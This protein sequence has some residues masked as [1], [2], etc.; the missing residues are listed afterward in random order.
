MISISA[1]FHATAPAGSCRS[2]HGYL[3]WKWLSLTSGRAGFFL[4]FTL[5]LCSGMGFA[6][7]PVITRAP[8]SREYFSGSNGNFSVT[9][10][11][12]ATLAYQWYKDGVILSNAAGK[13]S[14]A[15]ASS[16]SVTNLVPGDAGTYACRVS[17][18]EGTAY[19]PGAIARILESKPLPTL[20]NIPQAVVVPASGWTLSSAMTGSLPLSYQ[21]TLNSVDIAGATSSTLSLAFDPQVAGTYALRVTNGFGTTTG[22]PIAVAVGDQLFQIQDQTPANVEGRALVKILDQNTV[23]PDADIPG[24]TFG[25][26]GKMRFREGSILFTAG[27]SFGSNGLYRWK[28]GTLERIASTDTTSLDP[29]GRR[30]SVISY[31]TEEIGGVFYFVAETFVVG[32]FSPLI[33]IYKWNNGA[34]TRVISTGDVPP[35]GGQYFGFGQLAARGDTV[36]WASA[37]SAGNKI[38]R[39]NAAGVSLVLDTTMELPGSFRH[40][41]GVPGDKPQFSFDGEYLLATLQDDSSTPVK[42]LFAFDAN[43]QAILLADSTQRS[44]FSDLGQGDREAGGWVFSGGSNYEAAFSLPGGTMQPDR[45]VTSGSNLTAAA[46]DE[47]FN[48]NPFLEHSGP[49]FRIKSVSDGILDGSAI[50]NVFNVE[51]DGRELAAWVRVQSGNSHAIYA[52]IEPAS[53]TVPVVTY[54]TPSP[55]LPMLGGRAFTFRAVATGGGLSW[56]WSRNGNPIPGATRPFL[57]LPTLS[58]AD[59]GNYTVTVTNNVSSATSGMC[60]IGVIVPP[61]VPAYP[62]SAPA[63]IT[64]SPPQRIISGQTGILNLLSNVNPG[65]LETSYEWFR[66]GVP[67]FTTGSTTL[68]L[69]PP[70]VGTYTARITNAAGSTWSQPVT[71][72]YPAVAGSPAISSTS[73]SNGVFTLVFPS[74]LG[75]SYRVEYSPNLGGTPWTPLGTYPGTGAEITLQY[76]AFGGTGFYQVVELEQ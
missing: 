37:T 42:G 67:I 20:T 19:S 21:W 25:T 5:L 32:S 40:F 68:T 50:I 10:T 6:A 23:A 39:K 65:G 29:E 76:S 27:G 52:S 7:L 2:L 72:S 58:G 30:F 75:R 45:F 38:Y 31:P 22:P 1:L 17:N 44:N 8:A 56:Q 62:T 60:T 36:Y 28:A 63:F 16:L 12:T 43:H 4:F 53:E 24:T 15:T 55:S 49:G 51:A 71:V 9:A 59:A 70:A 18:A 11:G 13:I 33:A 54:V 48:S 61:A 3:E 69:N 57:V 74:L 34:M 73:L 41:Y 46:S 64:L 14:G 47:Y 35:D 26:F 66:D